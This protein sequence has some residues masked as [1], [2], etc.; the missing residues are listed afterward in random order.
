[1]QIIWTLLRC[2]HL[3]TQKKNF[4]AWMLFLTQPTGSKH[5]AA[6]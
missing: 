6:E 3:I 2:H 4:A 5:C 1:M